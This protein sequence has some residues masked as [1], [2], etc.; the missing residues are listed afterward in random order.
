MYN[1]LFTKILD[2]SVWLES[3]TTRIVWLTFIA[4][5]DED[6]FAA[7]A[8]VGNLANRARVSLHQCE[9]ALKTLEAPDAESADPEHEG[10]RIERVPGGW[11]VLNAAK[12]RTMVTR[13]VAQE[14]TRERVRKHRSKKAVT[15]GNASVTVSNDPVTPSEAYTEADTET[16]AEAKSATTNAHALTVNPHS[17]STN[18]INGAEQRRHASH[19]WCDRERGQCVPA[20]LH[21]EIKA[22]TGKP[23]AEIRAFYSAAMK[24][25]TQPL[26]SDVFK[27]WNRLVDQWTG[28]QLPVGAQ[29][30][31]LSRTEESMAASDR[32]AARIDAMKALGEL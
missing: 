9:E 11:V 20:S 21:E 22:R 15:V 14:R 16:K 17:K 27:F 4:A 29:Q 19:G 6:G 32:V 3:V 18:L 26:P 5:M 28:A 23:D 13:V 10:R 30:R 24:T 31:R 1:K 25:W 12:Y 7:F 2:S 8:A